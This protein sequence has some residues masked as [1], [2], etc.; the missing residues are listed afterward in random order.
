MTSCFPIAS[1]VPGLSGPPQWYD[2]GGATRPYDDDIDD[3]RWRGASRHG[4]DSGVGE[5]GIFRALHAIEGGKPVLYLS[6]RVLHDPS[7]IPNSDEIYVGFQRSASQR[8]VAH[9]VAYASVAADFRAH[10]TAGNTWLSISPAGAATNLTVPDWLNVGTKAWLTRPSGGG[11]SYE[12]AIAMRVPLHLGPDW[13]DDGI[14]LGD[15]AGGASFNF[16]YGIVKDMDDVAAAYYWPRTTQI[17][18]VGLNNVFPTAAWDDAHLD[19][20]AGCG[21]GIALSAIDVGTTNTDPMTGLAAPNLILVSTAT[22]KT[23]T[24]FARP[25]NTGAAVPPG[26][27][28][29]TFRTANWGSQAD[30]TFADVGT[31]WEE[32]L[33]GTPKVSV[34]T[35]PGG[36]QIT[37][38]WTIS[39]GEAA[40]WIPPAG[41]KWTHQCM[42]V[43]LS[44]PYDFINDSVYRNM[45]FRQASEFE[46]LAQ[47]SVEG[48]RPLP[49]ATRTIYL[50]V[51]R[52]NMPHD[53]EGGD[54]PSGGDGPP[55][56]PRLREAGATAEWDEGSPPNGDG[57]P[58]SEEPPPS[59]DDVASQYP[60]VRFHVFHETGG[61]IN[62][63]GR[64][65]PV[66]SAQTAFGHFV[67]HKGDAYGWDVVLGG[68]FKKIADNLFRLEVPEG[69][70]KVI[71]TK[72][73]AWEEPPSGARPETEPGPKQPDE[74]GD[75]DDP[76]GCL[77]MVAGALEALARLV[78]RLEKL[79][80]RMDTRRR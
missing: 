58:P 24:L 38:D 35:I 32:I 13:D 74:D 36:G 4:Y 29:A 30:F 22:P 64:V 50:Y 49:V 44:G 3:P 15:V 68:E 46:Q 43:T 73:H 21:T 41:H 52:N 57:S 19:A 17:A 33:P 39:T 65:K 20:G 59:I 27:L 69:G 42:L 10:I 75:D 47:I 48:L 76:K 11:T 40:D 5:E 18:V 63:N 23:N 61:F 55:P 79:V 26:G 9:I 71:N 51:E 72:V 2:T 70:K 67:E 77:P 66:V 25:T 6:W 45:D 8:Y 60:T 78:K 56:V 34:G 62:V 12:W 14:N 1:G 16:W 54:G 31:P 28:S 80:M 37:F 53:R 7:G